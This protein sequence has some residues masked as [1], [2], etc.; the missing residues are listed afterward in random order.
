MKPTAPT[1]TAW[2]TQTCRLPG[3]D[4]LVAVK[5]HRLCVGHYSRLCRK[6]KVGAAELRPRRNL[7]PFA[8]R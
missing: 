4:K 6:G 2:R 7:R 1:D 8:G 3:C 5:K